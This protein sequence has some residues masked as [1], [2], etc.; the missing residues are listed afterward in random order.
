MG[1]TK[2]SGMGGMLVI[3]VIAFIIA[4]IAFYGLNHLVMGVQGL[5]LNLDL[6]PAG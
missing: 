1:N 3:S 4:L 2:L 6:S 5:P